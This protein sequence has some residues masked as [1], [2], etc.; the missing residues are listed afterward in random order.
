MCGHTR[1]A[2]FGQKV[3][4]APRSGRRHTGHVLAEATD[5][6]LL[7]AAR[8]GEPA[9]LGELLERY[10]P[11][12]YAAALARLRDRD[13]ALDQVQE[14]LLVA[15]T[16]LQDVRD[17][18]A[19]GG[20]LH[21]VLRNGCLMQLRRAR[22]EVPVSE[23]VEAVDDISPEALFE[24]RAL[25]DWV[26]SALDALPDEERLTVLLRHFTRC[27][28]YQAIASVTGVPIGTVR[29]RLNRGRTRLVGALT[30][31]ADAAYDGHS[32]LRAARQRE[33]EDFYRA[34]Q[35]APQPRLFHDLFSDDVLAR[36]PNAT[37]NGLAD[38]VNEERAA[39]ELGVR[40]DLVA[41]VAGRGLTVL[42][43]DFHNPADAPGHCPPSSTFVHRLRGNRTAALEI[44]YHSQRAGIGS[45]T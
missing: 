36:D 33:W 30:A 37:W 34:V 7:R 28:S 24:R 19:V 32:K 11:S 31:T 13:K 23:L 2:R 12:L 17:P 18:D 35:M 4:S 44:Y 25:G 41:V 21:A 43:L 9:A 3:R 10:R 20:W 45:A 42:E 6:E 16:R 22:R 1:D 26:H 15:L 29:S 27:T 8:A 40:A 5:A 39:I 14:T 38:W